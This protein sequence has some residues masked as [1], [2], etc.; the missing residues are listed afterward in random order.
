MRRTEAARYARWSAGVAMVLVAITLGVYVQ[1]GWVARRERRKAPPPAPPSVEKQ[2]TALTFSKVEGNRTLFT[3]RASRSTQFRGRAEDLLEDVQITIFGRNGE[4][5]DTIHT[6]SCQY[7]KDGGRIACAGEV[8]MELQSAADAER[9]AQERGAPATRTVHV[10]TRGVS[11]DRESGVARTEQT[12]KFAFPDGEGQAQG[13]EYRSDEGLL[14]LEKDVRLRVKRLAEGRG[15]AAGVAGE[16]VNLTGAS[17]EYRREQRVMKL[18][19]PVHAVSEAAELAAGEMTLELDANYRAQRLV[20][21]A[22]AASG[23][24]P[25]VRAQRRGGAG[26]VSADEMVAELDAGGA[27]RQVQ[28][29]GQVQGEFLNGAVAT[30]LAAQHVALEFAGRSAEPQQLTAT[31]AVQA[32]TRAARPGGAG[33]TLR[34][35]QS[36]AVRLKFARRGAKGGAR[37]ES[38]ETLAPGSLEWVDRF[39]VTP[40][41]ESGAGQ[42]AMRLQA[43]HIQLALLPNGRAGEALARGNV[44]IQRTLPGRPEETSTAR[45]GTARFDAQGDWTEMTLRGDVKVRAGERRGQADT[46]V[47]VRAAQTAQL[48]GNAL[49]SDAGT[50]TTAHTITFYQTTGEI[51]AEG[52]VRSTD[53]APRGGA[54]QLAP[55][56]ANLSAERLQANAQT[57]RAVYSGHARLWQGD[58]VLEADRIEMLRNERVLNASGNVR[59]VFPQTAAAPGAA[60]SRAQGAGRGGPALWHVQAGTL[61]YREAESRARLEGQ[62]LAQS[63]GQSIRAAALDLEFRRGA[64]GGAQ[65]LSRAVGT[66]GVTVAQD[67]RRGTAERAEYSVKEGKFVLS[68]G[69]PTLYDEASGTTTGRQLTFFLADDTI[70]VDSEKGTRTLTK[71]RVEK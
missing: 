35:L 18:G 7:T 68:G 46:A 65:Q 23:A 70:I 17:L 6:R 43:E 21:K 56:P 32:E 27:V 36:E 60:G 47:F 50:R 49:V 26:R 67:G 15:K 38:A 58:S 30:T 12:V 25:E 69:N 11:F 71:H 3:V 29:T 16:E 33:E 34:R 42:S 1:R 55:V 41:E 5:H 52:G 22:G 51:L 64:N 37:L 63:A 45:E 8:Q 54:V 10:E 31:G 39:A 20:A 62:V 9:A 28:G 24:R 13:L 53:L 4:R 48:S 44:Q 14:R 61:S 66:G 59:A 57:G 40:G 19:G 2:S